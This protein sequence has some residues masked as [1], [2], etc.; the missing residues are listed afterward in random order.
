MK[1][2]IYVE[3]TADS[4]VVEAVKYYEGKQEGLGERFLKHWEQTLEL[5]KQNPNLYQ[6]KHKHYRQI[7]I[8]PFPYHIIY[9][10]EQNNIFVYKVPYG[11]MHPRKRYT[12][13]QP[14]KK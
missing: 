5:L 10:I 2:V 8:K 6:K 7:L 3:D 4:D 11:G 12:K 9:E 14:A 1:Y 13:K